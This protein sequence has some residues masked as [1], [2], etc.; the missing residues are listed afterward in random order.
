MRS[1]TVIEFLSDP[2]PKGNQIVITTTATSGHS[3][4]TADTYRNVVVGASGSFTITITQT[5]RCGYGLHHPKRWFARPGSD[6]RQSNPGRSSRGAAYKSARSIESTTV[7][8][9]AK[10][11]A[12]P[13]SGRNHKV[14]HLSLG[15]RAA[16]GKA[17]RT[18]VP[19]SVHGEWSAPAAR[20]DPVELLEEQA[21]SRVP[22][23]VP[24]RYGR[25]LVSPFTSS[26]SRCGVPDGDVAGAQRTG[27]RVQLCGDAHL[28]NFGAFASPDG[29]S[30]SI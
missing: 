6:R 3:E 23:L 28:S 27:L 5:A 2:T 30:C 24:I 15:E 1:A 20:R 18:E 7:G 14:P 21:A 11:T 4:V 8:E 17:E 19:R 29:G 22:D 16:R 12:P 26:L 10:R 13:G 9:V 25:M